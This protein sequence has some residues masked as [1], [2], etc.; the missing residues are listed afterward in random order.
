MDRSFGGHAAAEFAAAPIR[1]SPE[2]HV[3]IFVPEPFSWSYASNILNHIT[4]LSFS[5]LVENLCSDGVAQI[6]IDILLLYAMELSNLKPG[7][8]GNRRL[9]RL[10]LGIEGDARLII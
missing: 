10:Q 7:L 8:E 6:I 3:A 9:D 1:R 2:F 4:Y 5:E